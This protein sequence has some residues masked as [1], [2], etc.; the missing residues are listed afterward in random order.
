MSAECS[1]HGCD[2]V[3]EYSGNMVC[4]WCIY[5]AQ[6]E[7]LKAAM[8]DRCWYCRLGYP[9]IRYEPWD[10]YGSPYRHEEADGALRIYN[11]CH[12]PERQQRA[13]AGRTQ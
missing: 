5:E 9:L 10:K 1:L 2:L 7:E 11:R 3:Q 12:L 4:M 6:I 8:R 13:L